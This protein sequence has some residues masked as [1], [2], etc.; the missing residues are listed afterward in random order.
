MDKNLPF[1]DIKG[2]KIQ[3]AFKGRSLWQARSEDFSGAYAW[4]I[5]S[6][7]LCSFAKQRTNFPHV[8]MDGYEIC[9]V[10]EGSG[11]YRHGKEEFPL[12]PGDLFLADPEVVHEISSH[13][14]ADLLLAFFKIF[15]AHGAGPDLAAATPADASIDRFL[16]SHA[17]LRRAC[18]DMID[19]AMLLSRR[20]HPPEGGSHE[21]ELLWRAFVFEC[22][23]RLSLEI[24]DGARP[25]RSHGSTALDKADGFITAN[26]GRPLSVRELA[27]AS[28]LSER[29]LRRLFKSQFGCGVS[30]RIA[31]ARIRRA[32]HFLGM[33]FSVRETARMIGESSQAQFCRLFKRRVGV[34]PKQYQDR[35][36]PRKA[37]G[38]WIS[39]RVEGREA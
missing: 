36:S 28:G 12:E 27:N 34:S 30:E 4:T 1:S 32:K 11:Q 14:T 10:V 15:I 25:G 7:S 31:D 13:E 6:G 19:Y 5:Q 3:G 8:H 35:Y 26:S 37:S 9:L 22:L 18:D 33:R 16:K 29:Q 21:S 23:G 39:H 20:R 38:S 2:G 24:P 17:V